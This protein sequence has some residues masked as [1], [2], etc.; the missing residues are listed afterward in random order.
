MGALH[1]KVACRRAGAARDGTSKR[2][3][4]QASA[5]EAFPGYWPPLPNFAVRCWGA[6]GAGSAP[7][8][9]FLRSKA[10][11]SSIAAKLLASVLP[12]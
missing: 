7:V 4:A 3:A 11:T 1:V 12:A 9:V 8:V 6:V 2:G 5:A 10:P